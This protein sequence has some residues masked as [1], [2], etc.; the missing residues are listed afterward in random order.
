[1]TR[2]LLSFQHYR[3]AWTV[4]F[5]QDNCR[6]TIGSRTRYFTFA[7][8]DTLRSFVIRC[9][10]ED[11]TLAEVPTP[12]LTSRTWTVATCSTASNSPEGVGTKFSETWAASRTRLILSQS[13]RSVSGGNGMTMRG[14]PE[15]LSYVLALL[16][17]HN[18]AGG[19]GILSEQVS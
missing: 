10:P 16:F 3:D 5:V 7:A 1:M 6:T 9:Q 2:V 17:V 18:H 19:G 8:L 13:K 4:H 14:R 15:F 11:T 12:C